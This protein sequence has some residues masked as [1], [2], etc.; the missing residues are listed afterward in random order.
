MTGSEHLMS[1]LCINTLL[2]GIAIESLKYCGTVVG[3]SIPVS[4]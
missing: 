1:R 2:P 3:I 4:H